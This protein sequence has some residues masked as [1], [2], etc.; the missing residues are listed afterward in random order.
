MKSWLVKNVNLIRNFSEPS[1]KNTELANCKW[2][3]I[4]YLIYTGNTGMLDWIMD[5]YDVSLIDALK[6]G[7]DEEKTWE[8]SG[9]QISSFGIYAGL[10][11]RWNKKGLIH[12]A[13]K[14][15]SAIQ[16]DDLKAIV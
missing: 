13:Q 6:D 10:M 16:I 2:N 8:I 15:P 3:V 4:N 14:Y 5:T 1:L 7:G 11:R 12:L 9:V